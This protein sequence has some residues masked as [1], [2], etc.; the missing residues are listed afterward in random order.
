MQ[1]YNTILINF[2]L[3]SKAKY[4]VES[5]LEGILKI[6]TKIVFSI[7]RIDIYFQEAI[8]PITG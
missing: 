3:K 4:A 8:L 2:S 5:I 6:Q 7:L 1:I